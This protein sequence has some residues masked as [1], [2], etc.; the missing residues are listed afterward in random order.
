MLD[1]R[2]NN[3]MVR[4]V[5][6]LTIKYHA[7]NLEKYLTIAMAVLRSQTQFIPGTYTR[8]ELSV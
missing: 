7:Y 1:L 8:L 3:L 2:G 4:W 6:W 5:A